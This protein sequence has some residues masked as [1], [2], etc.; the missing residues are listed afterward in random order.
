MELRGKLP[1][2][3]LQSNCNSSPEHHPACGGDGRMTHHWLVNKEYWC[4]LPIF[5]SCTFALSTCSN[6]GL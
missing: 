3:G 6:S 1:T 2:E 4:V 5:R